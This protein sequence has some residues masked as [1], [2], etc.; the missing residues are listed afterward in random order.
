[1]SITTVISK[2]TEL[3]KPLAQV[4]DDYYS[5]IPSFMY[6]PVKSVNVFPAAGISI[7]SALN[8]E[9]LTLT[10]SDQSN[11]L[12][13]TRPLEQIAHWLHFRAGMLEETIVT[14]NLKAR[15]ITLNAK[16]KDQ[17]LSK[18]T[19]LV[20]D[21]ISTSFKKTP[22]FGKRKETESD[23][24]DFEMIK[25]SYPEDVQASSFVWPFIINTNK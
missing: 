7:K 12:S 24:E 5:N 16:D 10:V 3:T 19:E 15:M 2:S 4:I 8:G 1:M 18:T 20:E 23:K 9:N 11:N 25:R 13:S 21:F 17:L 14:L 22:A 6:M